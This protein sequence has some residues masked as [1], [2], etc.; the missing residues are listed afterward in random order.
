MSWSIFINNRINTISILHRIRCKAHNHI[1]VLTC[2]MNMYMTIMKNCLE[3]SSN[4]S[5]YLL[6]SIESTFTDSSRECWYLLYSNN[7]LICNQEKIEFII[8][9]RKEN[10][11]KKKH[12]VQTESAPKYW[13]SKYCNKCSLD[14]EYYNSCKYE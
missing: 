10:K 6:Y 9:P 4:F 8:D 13:S 11:S 12:P 5:I 7:S 1:W 14:I 2:C 3:Y